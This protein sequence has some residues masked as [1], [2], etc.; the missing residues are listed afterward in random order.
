VSDEMMYFKDEEDMRSAMYGDDKD[1][2]R[3]V[4]EAVLRDRVAFGDKS[5]EPEEEVVEETTEEPIESFEPFVP[6]PVPEEKDIS[7]QLE[8]QNRKLKDLYAQKAEE[9]EAELARQI[10]ERDEKIRIYEESQKR[11]V[12]ENKIE[13]IVLDD[14]DED[15]AS[16]YSRNT[17]KLMEAELEAFKSKI[18]NPVLEQELAEIKAKLAAEEAKN[19]AAE[20][21]RRAEESRKRLYESLDSFAKGKKEYELPVRVADAVNETNDL[22]DRIGE[23]FNTDDP[24]EVEKIYRR[25]IKEDTVY[26]REKKAELLK[27]GV[28]LPAYAKNYLNIVEV[29]ELQRGRKFNVV[30]GVYEDAVLS[31]EDAY[32]LNNFNTLVSKA[33]ST[34]AKEIQKKLEQQQTSAVT[35]SNADTSDAGGGSAYTTEEIM[36]AIRMNATDLVKNKVLAKKYT[37]YLRDEGLGVPPIFKNI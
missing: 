24:A 7:V 20:D 17:R 29:Y 35:M 2:A 34:E 13:N 12:E 21:E 37:Q 31:L 19:K 27:A 23:V 26:S 25:V 5:D 22:K 18:N 28:A 4:T 14:E 32:K 15:L 30:A 16:T 1:L 8:E 6:D 9:R 11:K 36:T 33:G 10:A 3:S